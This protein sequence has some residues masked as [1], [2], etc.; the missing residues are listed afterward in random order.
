[1]AATIRSDG[2]KQAL[3][4]DGY[5]VV[6]NVLSAE[7]I[8]WMRGEVIALLAS[9][10]RPLYGGLCNGP[11]PRES[12]DLARQLLDD[13]RLA[14]HCGSELPCEI[15]VHADTISNWH[16]DLGPP[17][18][19]DMFSGAPAW[20][21]KIAI[22][23]QDH[24]NRDGFS[25]VPGSHKEAN[26]PCPPLHL[27]TR[28]GDIIVFD[29]RIRHAGRLPNRIECLFTT[30]LWRLYQLRPRLIAETG[31]HLFRLFQQL[32]H[33][34]APAERLAIFLYYARSRDLPGRYV[35]LREARPIIR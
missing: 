5:A 9:K 29:L 34:R 12:S 27:A 23:L 28:A 16:T 18:R 35:A 26:P 17:A 19:T 32:R 20:M 30:P 11:V 33:L 8:A 7:E 1:M 25:V 13:T 22:L 15:H 10:A 14:S 31:Q 2:T 24:P 21:Y 4:R 3:E 6:T